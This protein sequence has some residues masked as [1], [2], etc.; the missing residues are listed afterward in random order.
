M[1]VFVGVMCIHEI[2]RSFLRNLSACISL[3]AEWHQKRERGE[4]GSGKYSR[5]MAWH[6]TVNPRLWALAWGAL[7]LCGWL[8]NVY[9]RDGRMNH[10]IVKGVVLERGTEQG[11]GRRAREDKK[12]K[13]WNK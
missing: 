6:F 3:R 7:S 12:V 4:E 2:R 9:C 13:R 11:Q 1:Q 5:Y 8:R 10:E